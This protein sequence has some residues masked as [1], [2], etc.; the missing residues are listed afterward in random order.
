MSYFYGFLG[1]LLDAAANHYGMM[2]WVL[3][4]IVA[5]GLMIRGLHLVD[6]V[7]FIH[8]YWF[9]VWIKCMWSIQL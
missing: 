9:C 1:L 8:I 5:T 3:R 4:F 2:T 7:L 6:L